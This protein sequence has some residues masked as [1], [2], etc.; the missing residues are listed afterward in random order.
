MAQ[1]KTNE[2]LAVAI[3]HRLKQPSKKRSNAIMQKLH[4][5]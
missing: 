5:S 4:T 2:L 1:H 3:A